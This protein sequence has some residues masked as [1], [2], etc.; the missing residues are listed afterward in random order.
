M[1]FHLLVMAASTTAAPTSQAGARIGTI[2]SLWAETTT[3]ICAINR[4]NGAK[5]LLALQ[6]FPVQEQIN[7]RI[8][9]LNGWPEGEV[10]AKIPVALKVPIPPFEG[11]I[12]HVGIFVV[13]IAERTHRFHFSVSLVP[14]LKDDRPIELEGATLINR[15]ATLTISAPSPTGAG[16][17]ENIGSGFCEAQADDE[18]FSI[19]G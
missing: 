13:P 5:T 11:G 9:G 8:V 4:P 12:S 3:Y 19:V 17:S 16:P 10:S 7:L 15:S 18:V 1:L 14:L 6:T 2:E